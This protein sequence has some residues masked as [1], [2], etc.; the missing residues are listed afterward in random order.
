MGVKILTIVVLNLRFT[1]FPGTTEYP[2][3]LSNLIFKLSIDHRDIINL[4][5]TIKII[6][7]FLP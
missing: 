5:K 2:P 6:I 4:I 3:P 1:R 7:N